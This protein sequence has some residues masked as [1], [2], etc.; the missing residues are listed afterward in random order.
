MSDDSDKKDGQKAEIISFPTL[1]ERDRIEREKREAQSAKQKRTVKGWGISYKNTQWSSGDGSPVAPNSKGNS[2]VI[3][4]EPFLKTGNIP[5]FTKFAALAIIV[6]HVLA[7][8]VIPKAT[9]GDLRM[10]F[11]FIPGV[12]TGAEP[13]TSLF[14]LLSPFTYLLLHADWMHVIL[15][16]L[17]LLAFGIF[18]EK[19][20]GM[21]GTIFFFFAGGLAFAG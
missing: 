10:T 17:M 7:S 11:T 16:T 6:I 15:N 1:K 8:F 21:K 18:V 19:R 14:S 2:G 3:H 9:L 20:L 13:M 4:K 12:F 5:P